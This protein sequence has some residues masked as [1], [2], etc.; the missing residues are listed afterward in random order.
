MDG[1]IC[2]GDI[3]CQEGQRLGDFSM[4]REIHSDVSD[5]S[6][7]LSSE[8]W[9][10]LPKGLGYILGGRVVWMN[11]SLGASSSSLLSCS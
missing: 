8:L 7:L 4:Y 5:P 2:V 11:R 9:K 1:K 6:P 3:D 10:E